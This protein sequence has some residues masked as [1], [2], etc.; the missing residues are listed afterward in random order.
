MYLRIRNLVQTH[1][2]IESWIN[3][4][5]LMTKKL[6]LTP[7]FQIESLDHILY[8]FENQNLY[9]QNL[10]AYIKTGIEKRHHLLIIENEKIYYEVKGIINT[11]FSSEE[12]DFIHYVDNVTFYGCYG[13]FHMHNIVE[14][15]SDILDP[16]IK[17]N[18]TIRTWAH[19]EWKEQDAISTKLEEFEQLADNAVNE[20]GIMSV[21]AYSG[22][23]LPASLQTTLMRSH[24]YLM[25]DQELF[26]ST[27][28]KNCIENRG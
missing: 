12:K 27:L 8:I 11:L 9:I 16:F 6:G 28:Y 1:I 2:L 20:I 14:H 24:K 26:H 10:I 23:E 5:V 22:L 19:V 3:K 4:V 7:H 25:T 15:F 13:D 18:I 17:N 21:C